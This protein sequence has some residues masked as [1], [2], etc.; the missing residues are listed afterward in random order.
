MIEISRIERNERKAFRALAVSVG[1]LVIVL[2]S[3]L[4]IGFAYRNAQLVRE[5][6]EDRGK[7]LFKQLVLTRRWAAAYGGVYVRKV[8][9][10]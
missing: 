8:E 2:L 4:F 9:G 7:S 1:A 3:G 6:V 10:V 5:V